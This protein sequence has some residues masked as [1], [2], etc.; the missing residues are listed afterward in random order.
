MQHLDNAA[1][2][3]GDA[4]GDNLHPFAP[5]ATVSDDSVVHDLYARVPHEH[6]RVSISA[7][8]DNTAAD[9]TRPPGQAAVLPG[10]PELGDVLDA[11]SGHEFEVVLDTASGHES[12]P[13]S[14]DNMPAPDPARPMPVEPGG[15]CDV[16]A[17]VA[18]RRTAADGVP[19]ADVPDPGGASINHRFCVCARRCVWCASGPPVWAARQGHAHGQDFLDR[20]RCGRRWYLR[21][22]RF[23]GCCHEVCDVRA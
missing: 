12:E 14:A 22:Q 19:M 23:Y 5:L 20:A 11:A 7:A 4:A 2:C 6:R 21:R 10:T 15:A 1:I 17:H 9:H 3:K 8:S 13:A 18:S 16:G